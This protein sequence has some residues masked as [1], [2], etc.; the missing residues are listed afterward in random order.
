M[1]WRIISLVALLGRSAAATYADSEVCAQCH[2][3]IAEAYARTGMARSLFRPLPSNA[4]EDYRKRHEFLHSL[5]GTQYAMIERGGAYFQRRWQ[6]GFDGRETNVE[7]LSIDAV[8]GSGNHARSY[9][10]RTAVGGDRK[11]VV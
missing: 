3:A 5:S 2:S 4:I 7:E 6:I 1:V 8:I 11:S 9:L 10:H